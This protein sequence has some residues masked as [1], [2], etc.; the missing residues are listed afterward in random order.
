MTIGEVIKKHRQLK[1][2]SQRQFASQCNVSHAYICMLEKGE[3]PKTKEPITPSLISLK[4]V[5]KGMG[6]SLH[7]LI[8]QADDMEVNISD[9]RGYQEIYIP[10]LKKVPLLGKTACGEPIYSPN[11]DDGFALIGEEYDVDFALEA[12]GDSMIGA[13]INDGD[14]VFF[15][16]QEAVDNGQIA[17]VFID[18]EVTLKRVYYY[19]E[20]SKLILQPENPK[21]EPFV[22]TGEELNSIRIIGLAVA[23]LRKL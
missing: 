3:H 5:A 9:L 7:D 15:K 11:L 21:C 2:I 18:D 1:N 23:H 6:I 13:G 4:K 16:A 17:A 22:Y 12:K 10:K 19:P 20:K 8:S 14:V